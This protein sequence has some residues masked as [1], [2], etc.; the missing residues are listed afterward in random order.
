M[1]DKK[2]YVD[3]H[4]TNVMESEW[5]ID[6]LHIGQFPEDWVKPGGFGMDYQRTS[7]NKSTTQQVL[8]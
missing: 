8:E 3:K 6:A 4:V 2:I 7:N 1:E 5:G